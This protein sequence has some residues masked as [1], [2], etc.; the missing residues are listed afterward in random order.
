MSTPNSSLSRKGFL[1]GTAGVIAG[2][3]TVVHASVLGRG[4]TPRLVT[5]SQSG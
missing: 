5:A 4:A 2:F 3:P 1:A